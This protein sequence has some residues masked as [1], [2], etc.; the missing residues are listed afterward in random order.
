MA[1][2]P[3]IHRRLPPLV[4]LAIVAA[5]ALGA[6][7]DDPVDPGQASLDGLLL[8][9]G[10]LRA[11]T[12]LETCVG[13]PCRMA[14][15]ETPKGTTWIA[16][17]DGGQ[18]AATLLDQ[19]LRTSDA[20][21]PGGKQSWRK[22][23]LVDAEGAHVDGPFLFPSWDP[24]GV[25]Y[26]VLA[27][28]LD[29]DPR[30]VVADPETGTAVEHLLE[31]PIVPAPPAWLGE[32]RILVVTG[33]DDALTSSVVD[34]ASGDASAGPAGARLVATSADALT[35]A[36]AGPGRDPVAF[37]ATSDWLAGDGSS[38]AIDRSA[39]RC[40]DVI[41]LA[42]DTDG[43]RL[44]V[45][46]LTDGVGPGARLRARPRLAR[47]RCHGREPAAGGG[48][49]L[50]ALI[51]VAGLAVGRPRPAGLRR[52]RRPRSRTKI[53]TWASSGSITPKTFWRVRRWTHDP[54]LSK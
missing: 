41:A 5:L 9:T 53:E 20:L 27:G 30:L 51:R 46:W 22:A 29:A 23:D 54:Q 40:L 1:A 26:A 14:T 39:E 17:G 31:P 19:T 45:A 33:T 7:K 8:L 21:H 35:V 18:L 16:A 12:M 49:G 28:G 6:C 10:D 15:V 44:A 4:A 38:L 2:S 13:S 52:S 37:R 50:V 3:T 43:S 42:L 47:G 36:V 48:G 32:D 24:G 25:R 34:T 11:S